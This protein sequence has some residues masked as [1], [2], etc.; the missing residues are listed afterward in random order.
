MKVTHS[1]HRKHRNIEQSLALLR[2]LLEISSS[3]FCALASDLT[4]HLAADEDVLYPAVEEASAQ[5]FSSQRAQHARVR[6]AAEGAAS[7]L[8]DSRLLRARLVELAAAFAAHARL[9]EGALH[10]CLE[11]RMSLAS[12]EVLEAKLQ[13]F[14]GGAASRARAASATVA[15]LERPAVAAFGNTTVTANDRFELISLDRR[16][17]AVSGAVRRVGAM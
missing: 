4:A 3:D 11:S 8:G 13:T 7:C 15:V 2:D 9:E 10:A 12:L 5:I 1:L 6:A 16:V 14:R 17:A